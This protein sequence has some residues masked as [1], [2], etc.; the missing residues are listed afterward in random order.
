[1]AELARLRLGPEEVDRL[2]S[3]LASILD[4]MEVLGQVDTSAVE[5]PG[6]PTGEE[7]GP[8]EGA[9]LRGGE[10]PPDALRDSPSAMAPGWSDGFFVV[11][12]LPAMEDEME[13]APPPE[14][15]GG[16]AEEGSR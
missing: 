7:P 12:R 15:E 13:N 8:S 14:A 3:E 2:T 16:E 11:P 9:P 6:R 1:M 5:G 4:H 10:E